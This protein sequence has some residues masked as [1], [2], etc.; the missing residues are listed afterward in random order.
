MTNINELTTPCKITN[1]A[2]NLHNASKSEGVPQTLA[3]VSTKVLWSV[4]T[5]TKTRNPTRKLK[6]Q[7]TKHVSTRA[8]NPLREVP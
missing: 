3:T 1:A 7:T 8:I 5:E 6:A 2:A 4:K